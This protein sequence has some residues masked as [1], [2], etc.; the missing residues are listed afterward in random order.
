MIGYLVYELF[1][2]SSCLVFINSLSTHIILFM[3]TLVLLIIVLFVHCEIASIGKKTKP[4]PF[5]S[6]K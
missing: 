1:L 6:G 2:R 5:K 4:E 3:Q